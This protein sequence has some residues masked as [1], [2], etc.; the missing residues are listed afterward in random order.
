M[1]DMISGGDIVLAGL[2][3]PPVIGNSKEVFPKILSQKIKKTC[4]R[5]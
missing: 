4:G 3:Q 5:S 2:Q 1:Q